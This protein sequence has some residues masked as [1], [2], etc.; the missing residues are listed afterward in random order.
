MTDLS[1]LLSGVGGQGIVLA[2]KLLAQTAID[3]GLCA[4]TCETIGMA[5]RGGCVVSHV[6]SGENC[7]SPIIPQGTAQ[8]LLG[9]EPAEAVR[10]LSI[11]AQDGICITATRGIRPV[12]ASLGTGYGEEAI[13]AYLKTHAPRLILVN[14]EAL[15]QEAGSAKCL[16][17]IM[18]GTAAGSGAFPFP[19]ESFLDAIAA[20]FPQKYVEPNLRAFQIGY[21]YG[22]KMMSHDE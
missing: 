5:Q 20:N 22:K 1:C 15:L 18:V 8:V 11:L 19:R 14:A 2:S 16:N 21:T 10:H 12:T 13:L 3:N 6:R 17:T 9:F 7:I 4:Q